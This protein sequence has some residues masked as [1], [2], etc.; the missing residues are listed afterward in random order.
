MQSRAATTVRLIQSAPWMSA[1]E[2]YTYFQ[3]DEK[4]SARSL[5]S[6]VFFGGDGTEV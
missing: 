1:H 4:H 3:L 6:S 2:T 5:S